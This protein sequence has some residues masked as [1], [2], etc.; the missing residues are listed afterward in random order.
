MGVGGSCESDSDS[1]AR[2]AFEG[3]VNRSAR[4]MEIVLPIK[5]CQ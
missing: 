3:V 2:Y 5:V 4:D 1:C